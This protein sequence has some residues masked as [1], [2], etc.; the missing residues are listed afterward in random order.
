MVELRREKD[1]T[2]AE[3]S[4]DKGRENLSLGLGRML[5]DFF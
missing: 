3:V 1:A 5:P 2:P 4:T